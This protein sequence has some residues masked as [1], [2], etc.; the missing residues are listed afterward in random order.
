MSLLFQLQRNTTGE[1][2]H[3]AGFATFCFVI[4]EAKGQTEDCLNF[5]FHTLKDA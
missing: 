3:A 5:A 4:C 1:M 2:Q